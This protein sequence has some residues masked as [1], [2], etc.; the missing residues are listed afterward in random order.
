M[1]H[2]RKST[3]FRPPPNFRIL[4]LP[5]RHLPARPSR[6]RNRDYAMNF[7]WICTILLFNLVVA[8]AFASIYLPRGAGARW[9]HFFAFPHGIAYVRLVAVELLEAE[10]LAVELLAAF[11]VP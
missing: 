10:L 6:R 5:S 8:D 1:G 3:R 2:E 7:Q 4:A 9:Q 11:L